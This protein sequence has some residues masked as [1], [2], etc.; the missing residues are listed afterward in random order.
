[1]FY[2]NPCGPYGPCAPNV[3]PPI[4][5]PPKHCYMNT[6]SSTLVPHIHPMQ[7][8]I[9]NHH[10]MKH[11][12]LF[13]QSTNFAKTCNNVNLGPVAGIAPFYGG[14]T[15]YSQPMM[16]TMPVSP[17][18]GMSPYTSYPTQMAPIPGV[19][20]VPNFLGMKGQF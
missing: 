6:F 5:H 19:K 20:E 3:A 18:V 4:V 8:T 12:H 16:P 9:V 7:T 17:S 2:G 14:A 11:A 1:M 15:P 10:T 13:P